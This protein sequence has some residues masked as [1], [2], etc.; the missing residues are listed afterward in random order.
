MRRY[1]AKETYDFKEP[2]NWSHPMPSGNYVWTRDC[3]G[4][5]TRA[6]QPLNYI[7]GSFEYEPCLP[8]TLFAEING[9]RREILRIMFLCR[10]VLRSLRV[11]GLQL[12]A[13]CG[14]AG[15][16]KRRDRGKQIMS[17]ICICV[18]V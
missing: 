3:Q 16:V 11:K 17:Y 6:L 15:E 12:N 4:S 1:P 7:Q 13:S 14:G 8:C 18:Y 5:F 2:T 10:M 9:A